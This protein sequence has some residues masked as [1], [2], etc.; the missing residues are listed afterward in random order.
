MVACGGIHERG[1]KGNEG[2]GGADIVTGEARKDLGETESLGLHRLLPGSCSAAV[3]V[4]KTAVPVTVPL[5]DGGGVREGTSGPHQLG[6][7]T[8]GGRVGWV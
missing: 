6:K 2:W 3:G 4:V 1:G 7:E 5:S 8:R